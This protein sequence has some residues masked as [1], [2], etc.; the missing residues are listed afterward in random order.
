MRVRLDPV[1]SHY[2]E[3]IGL[4]LSRSASNACAIAL[5]EY[6]RVHLG[7]AAT[8][9]A[10]PIDDAVSGRSMLALHC[11]PSLRA[12]VEQFANREDRS[13]SSAMKVL[14]RDALRLHGI[15][16]TGQRG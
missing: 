14:L 7:A 3:Q 16:P 6:V 15:L 10:Q 9:E 5:A 2:A 12:A 4:R 8:P 11:K 13:L 1:A